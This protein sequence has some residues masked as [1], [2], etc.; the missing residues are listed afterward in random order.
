MPPA[1]SMCPGPTIPAPRMRTCKSRPSW[2]W[3]R[4]SRPCRS[5]T[6][7]VT[8][9][10][11]DLKAHV[12]QKQKAQ[13]VTGSLALAD[14]TGQFG[15]NELR[16]FGATMDLDVG[17]TP[18]QVQIRKAT[19]K[20]TQGGNAGGSF[21][22]SATYDL[23]EEDRRP[24]R[25]A[26][27]FQPERAGA[28]PRAGAGRQEARVGGDQR[29]CHRPIRSARGIGGEGGLADDEP[30]G[31]GP[32]RASSPPRRWRRRCRWMPR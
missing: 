2:R 28:V 24:D 10:T 4:C 15:K 14:F 26:G 13:A 8:S 16:S 3:R 30:G 6:M 7:S 1:V 20:L 18:Q 12:T 21:D 5:R 29:Q 17:M 31:E 11:V 25:Q 9:G 19:G 32:H 23:V 22:L 27:G